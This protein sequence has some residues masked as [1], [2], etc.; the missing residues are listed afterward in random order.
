MQQSPSWEANWFSASQETPRILWKP[1]VHYH[2]YKCL[3]PILSHINPFH[4]P[5]SH[6]PKIHLNVILPSMLG[7][8]K[9]S[10]FLRFPHQNPVCTSSLPIRATC[11]TDFILLH[12]ITWIICGEEYRSL[13][14]SSCSFFHSCI[15]S[16]L[17][18][19]NILLS[20]LFSNALSLHSSLNVRDQASHPYKTTGNII[21][22]AYLKFYIF[23]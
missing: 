10:L 2:V 15:T 8:S 17:L 21:V 1:K 13:S 20:T 22:V 19:P 12:L 9:R 7:S 14:S 6:Y 4:A 5:T 3:T 11:P 16:S 23:G 18:G